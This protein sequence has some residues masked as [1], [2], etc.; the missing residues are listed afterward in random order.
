MNANGVT[1]QRTGRRETPVSNGTVRISRLQNRSGTRTLLYIALGLLSVAAGHSY[2]GQASTPSIKLSPGTVRM[3]TFYNGARVRVEGTVPADSE[4]LVVIRGE[5]RDEFF[6]KKGRVGPIWVNTD[7]IHVTRVPSLFLSF[8]SRDVNSILDRASIEAYQLDE[9]AIKNRMCCRSHCKCSTTKLL[10]MSGSRPACTGTEPDPA[11]QELIR[12]NY[13]ALKAREGSYEACLNTVR[14]ADSNE[15][16]HYSLDL[17]WPRTAP[18]GLYRVEVFACR[19]SVVMAQSSAIL[20]VVEVGFPAQI[21][22]LAEAQ[23]LKYGSTAVLVA[24]LAGFA[25]DALTSRLRRRSLHRA[26]PTAKSVTPSSLP[27]QESSHEALAE[28]EHVHH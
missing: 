26:V 13:V 27:E 11:Y 7:R 1:P 22:A 25:I 12:N 9:S 21:A 17:D 10:A 5:E 23:P 8:S 24:V 15:G 28:R 4:V 2:A 14:I 6:N 16:R 3:G 18:P 19:N 20:Q